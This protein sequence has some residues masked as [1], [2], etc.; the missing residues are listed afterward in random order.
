MRH[1]HSAEPPMIGNWGERMDGWRCLGR[2]VIMKQAGVSD[3][4][5]DD[6][7]STA[8]VTNQLN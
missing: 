3:V 7:S 1:S 6:A 8:S 4:E 5:S 2:F